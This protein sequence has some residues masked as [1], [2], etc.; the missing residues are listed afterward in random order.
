MTK[1][2]SIW[3][4][5]IILITTMFVLSACGGDAQSSNA[6][7]NGS[8]SGSNGSGRA[9]ATPFPTFAFVAP[10]NPPVF[11]QT[12]ESTPEATAGATAE[13]VVSDLDPVAVER[14]LGR[15]EALEC[16][17]CHG[18][19]GEGTDDG[20]AL[21]GLALSETDFITF[22]RSGGEIGTSHQYSTDRLSE[23]GALNLY[24]Y[25]LS[26]GE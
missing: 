10:T 14:G 16:A 11:N 23:R 12:A 7:D 3:K 13:A 15:Y 18:A 5:L 1:H 8:N 22:M 21:I 25:L 17:T 4:I 26:L 19:N 9:T 24:Q 20:S 2:T 6:T